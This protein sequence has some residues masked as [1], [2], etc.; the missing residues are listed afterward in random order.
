MLRERSQ[1]NG[2]KL[3]DVAQ[4]VVDSQL[5][6]LTPPPPEA[7]PEPVAVEPPRGVLGSDMEQKVKG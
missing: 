7:R 2:R 1:P 5:L 6:L 3:V 4:A